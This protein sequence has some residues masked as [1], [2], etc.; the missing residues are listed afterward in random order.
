M[1]SEYR[2]EIK[3]KLRQVCVLPEKP[4]GRKLASI[5]GGIGIRKFTM[6]DN[7]IAIKDSKHE[8]RKN[9][10]SSNSYDDRGSKIQA[11]HIGTTLGERRTKS[12]GSIVKSEVA[13]NYED[14]HDR[15]PII[16]GNV[17]IVENKVEDILTNMSKVIAKHSYNFPML[18]KDAQQELKLVSS[19][20]C[21]KQG[22]LF[23]SEV[24]K[25]GMYFSD[26]ALSRT[27]E[28]FNT[29]YDCN[30]VQIGPKKNTHSHSSSTSSSDGL[31]NELMPPPNVQIV[32]SEYDLIKLAKVCSNGQLAPVYIM[33]TVRFCK[34]TD[35]KDVFLGLF[36]EN[37]GQIFH[38][39]DP[40]TLKQCD[41]EI[42]SFIPL[43][44]TGF[45]IDEELS[46]LLLESKGLCFSKDGRKSK[47]ISDAFLT[48]RILSLYLSPEHSVVKDG[49]FSMLRAA[50]LSSK[51]R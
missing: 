10:M 43:G 46:F 3:A 31:S 19:A 50:I 24:Y 2:D 34:E 25:I 45:D 39:C 18:V 6:N 28:W 12:K 4:R 37:S 22:Y 17:T 29:S 5:E 27:I 40:K 11:G 26:S 36:G 32:M 8:S 48:N 44:H 41:K 15:R 33:F 9:G 7:Q 1:N 49:L 23:N 16:V 30:E 51:L 20:I 38:D 35:W 42:R 21:Y 13:Y 14:D 47:I